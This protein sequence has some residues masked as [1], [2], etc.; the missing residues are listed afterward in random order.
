[1]NS[2]VFALAVFDDGTGP[3][4][5]AGG[6]FTS[7]GG[8]PAARVAKWDGSA[9]S[10][11]SGPGFNGTS[12]EV[13]AL[14]AFDDGAGPALYAGGDFVYAGALVVNRIARWNGAAWSPLLGAGATGTGLPVMALAVYDDGGGAGLYAGGEFNHIGGVPVNFLAKWDG[15]AWSALSGPGATGTSDRV[16][17]VGVYDDGG[18][19]ALH[20]G[21]DFLR[22]GGTEVN[23]LARWDGAAWSGLGDPAGMADPWQEFTS[24]FV[25][26]LAAWDD[27]SGPALYAG[28][29]FSTAGGLPSRN[30]ARWLCTA[31]LF[32]DGFES[33]DVSAWSGATGG[34]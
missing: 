3:A 29:N 30:I 9:W 15:V 7:A 23:H 2:A 28:G 31:R 34:S 32:A 5:Y 1:M 8:V 20:A 18:G 14:A 17:A 27:G 16:L 12:D 22:A 24:S 13:L 6:E 10:A 11:L 19:P 21:G 33:G 25:S 26:A 4:L